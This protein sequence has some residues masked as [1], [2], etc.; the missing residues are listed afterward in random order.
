[1]SDG[2]LRAAA[3]VG[4]I[5]GF[6]SD[7]GQIN[8]LRSEE[9]AGE[10]RKQ[11]KRVILL[12]LAGGASQFETW[13]PKPGAKTGGPFRAIQT[14]ATGVHISELLPELSQ[15][16]ILIGDAISSIRPLSDH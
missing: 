15:R 10:L 8:V 5:G 7:M 6:S 16:I 12:W 4:V 1:M 11:D 2:T 14:N 13:D 3:T 9:V